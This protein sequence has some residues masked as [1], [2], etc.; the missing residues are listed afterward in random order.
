[1]L[2]DFDLC[3]FSGTTRLF[4]LGGIVMFPH[5]VVPL[6]IFEPRYRQMTEHALAGDRLITIIQALSP[7]SKADCDQPALAAVGCL[8]RIIRHESLVDGRFNFLLVGKARVRIVGELECS[9]LYRQAEVELLEDR[10]DQTAPCAI[11]EQLIS[12]FEKLYAA[13]L[14]TE[15]SEVLRRNRSLGALCDILAHAVSLTPAQKQHLL[16]EPHV[17]SRCQALLG[18][19]AEELQKRRIDPG[20]DRSFPPPFS[21][22]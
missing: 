2:D 18:F 17:P 4:P 20:P 7:G 5:V 3:H 8:G 19:L 22:N 12:R 10:D 15:M 13:G 16:D 6:H 11:R 1:M 9:T 14:E 21:D